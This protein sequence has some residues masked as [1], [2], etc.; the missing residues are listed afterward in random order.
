MKIEIEKYLKENRLR[1]DVD[2]PDEMRIWSGIRDKLKKDKAKSGNWFW[3]VAVV[4]LVAVLSTYITVKETSKEQVIVITLGDISKEL[5]QQEAE[6]KQIVDLKW[7]ELEPFSGKE[8]SEFKFIFD[9]LDE[10]DEIYKTY[11]QDLNTIGKNEQIINVLLDYYEK[12]IQLLNQLAL[13]IEKQKNH[14]NNITL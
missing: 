1:L 11:E 12:K 14:E 4:F 5:G 6:L 7:K 9:E 10:L 13:E 3:K 2:Q 8:K